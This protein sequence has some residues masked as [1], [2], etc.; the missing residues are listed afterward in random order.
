MSLSTYESHKLS[1]RIFEMEQMDKK[2]VNRFLNSIK[3]DTTI[4]NIIVQIMLILVAVVTYQFCTFFGLRAF[5]SNISY[6]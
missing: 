4:R 6:Q 5:F 2:I 3:I 1:S